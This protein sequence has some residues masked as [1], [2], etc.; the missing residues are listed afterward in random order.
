MS[1]GGWRRAEG[2][3]VAFL[4]RDALAFGG[5]ALEKGGSL[6]GVAPPHCKKEAGGTPFVPSGQAGAPK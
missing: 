5:E 2:T 1:S 4:Q 3:S 6:P